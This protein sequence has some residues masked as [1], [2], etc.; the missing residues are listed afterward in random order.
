[1][2]HNAQLSATGNGAVCAVFDGAAWQFEAFLRQRAGAAEY[3]RA[4]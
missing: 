1:L 3:R 4:E 2:T